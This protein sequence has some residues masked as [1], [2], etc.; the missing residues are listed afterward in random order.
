MLT[1]ENLSYWNGLQ[2]QVCENCMTA[3]VDRDGYATCYIDC[4]NKDS[5]RCV[6]EELFMELWYAFVKFHEFEN[7]NEGMSEDDPQFE[8]LERLEEAYDTAYD[9]LSCACDEVREE[10]YEDRRYA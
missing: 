4:P 1:R 8:E 10:Y 6:H 5:D 2:Q 3:D 9:R 7:A